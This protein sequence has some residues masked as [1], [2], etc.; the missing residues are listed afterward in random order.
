VTQK[1]ICMVGAAGVGKT[2]L[3]RRYVDSVF[4][5]RYHSTL[6]VKVDKKLVEVDG[7]E[8]SLVL[9]D[10]AGMDELSGVPASYLRGSAGY[11]LV[12]DGTRRETLGVAERLQADVERELG[13]VPFVVLLNKS[14]LSDEWQLGDAER[15]LS[16]R[17]WTGL[18]TSAKVGEGV[19]SAFCRLALQT[20]GR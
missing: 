6:G 1:K 8:V 19:E 20:L 9:W 13:H 15:E 10:L 16:E 5:E 11:L 2:S 7:Q 12:V 3:V 18:P 14:D 4:S 17:G